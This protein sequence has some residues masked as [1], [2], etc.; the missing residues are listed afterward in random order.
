MK[1]LQIGLSKWGIISALSWSFFAA[2][3]LTLRFYGSSEAMNYIGLVLPGVVLMAIISTIIGLFQ[4]FFT[5]PEDAKDSRIA[6][7]NGLSAR[8]LTILII[9]A[10]IISGYCALASLW[11]AA[12]SD[13]LQ[14]STVSNLVGLLSLL[15]VSWL[16]AV[17]KD[18]YWVSRKKAVKF[19]ERQIQE[20]QQVFERSYKWIAA[21]VAVTAWFLLAFQNLF[22]DA[23]V[24]PANDLLSGMIFWPFFLFAVL[25]FALPLI[26]AAWRHHA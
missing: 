4:G 2:S 12:S 24:N 16:S 22:H 10:I 20:R 19:D 25:I 6:K 17:Q 7:A 5:S 13:K 3:Y 21:L 18:I 14:L 15:L 11:T 8:V 26:I 23:Y 9:V 1:G